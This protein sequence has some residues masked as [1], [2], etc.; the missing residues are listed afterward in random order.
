MDKDLLKAIIAFIVTAGIGVIVSL[1]LSTILII[2]ESSKMQIFVICV[3]NMSIGY[4]LGM[5]AILV[6]I[7]FVLFKFKDKLMEVKADKVCE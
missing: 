5:L 1:I 4:T 2:S 3:A 6:P 7:T